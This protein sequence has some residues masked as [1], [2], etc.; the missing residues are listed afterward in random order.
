MIYT[1]IVHGW[2]AQKFDSETGDCVSQEFIAEEG[3]VE[4][5]DEEGNP[6]PPEEAQEL[7]NTEKEMTFDMVQP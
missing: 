6:I 4:R 3:T 1:R 2:V 7:E 5:E